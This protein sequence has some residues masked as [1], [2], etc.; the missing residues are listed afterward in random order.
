MTKSVLVAR[1]PP[2]LNSS[3]NIL[4][5]GTILKSITDSI[6]AVNMTGMIMI[7]LESRTVRL[8]IL[9]YLYSCLSD[10]Q[11][12]HRSRY[13]GTAVKRGNL[14]LCKLQSCFR[15]TRCIIETR[16]KTP[17]ATKWPQRDKLLN[18]MTPGI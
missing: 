13:A 17:A 16:W 6:V 3:R 15:L 18:L 1:M 8:M 2:R 11:H 14:Q 4:I 10:T 5:F 12:V 7:A 9:P